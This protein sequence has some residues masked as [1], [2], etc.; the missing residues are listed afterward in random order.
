MQF[1]GDQAM[2]E[3]CISG[4]GGEELLATCLAEKR[5]EGWQNSVE[6]FIVEKLRRKNSTEAAVKGENQVLN[7]KKN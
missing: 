1:S 6:V 2:G 5:W 4:T 3:E 7:V